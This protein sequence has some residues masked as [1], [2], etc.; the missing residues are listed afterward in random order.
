MI[1][2]TAFM[3]NKSRFFFYHFPKCHMK[4][5]PGGFNAKMGREIISNR[6]LAMRFYMRMAVV[7]VLEL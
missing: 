3:G 6:Q 1:Q 4:I 5:L 2:K 7:M